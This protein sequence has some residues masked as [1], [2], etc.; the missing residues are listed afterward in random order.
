MNRTRLP[1]TG[2]ALLL[3]AGACATV[4]ATDPA[5]AILGRWRGEN[6]RAAGTTLELHSDGEGVWM[7]ADTVAVTYRH[8]VLGSRHH[9][10]I[11]V[12]AGTLAGRTLYCL[13]QMP[14]AD[15]LRLHCV[16]GTDPAARPATIDEDQVQVFRRED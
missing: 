9:I 15:V 11:S 7:R 3:F 12:A 8:A 10:D 16:P 13:G 14:S 4:T 5:D 6:E 1:S 2:A